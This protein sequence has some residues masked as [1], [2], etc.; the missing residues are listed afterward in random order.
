M[1][2]T[3]GDVEAVVDLTG[4]MLTRLVNEG[5]SLEGLF[6]IVAN[7]LIGRTQP[8]D[9]GRA[10]E[11]TKNKILLTGFSKSLPDKIGSI[12]FNQEPFGLTPTREGSDF[13]QEGQ[14]RY[15]ARITVSAREERSAGEEAKRSLERLLDALR[16]ELIHDPISVHDEFI[17]IPSNQRPAMFRFP[18]TVPNPK[19]NIYQAEFAE[20]LSLLVGLYTSERFSSE[21]KSKLASALRCYRMSLDTSQFQNRLVNSWTALE[22]LA[23][24]RTQK[25]IIDGVRG[26]VV[27]LLVI[28]YLRT[29]L[30]DFRETLAF[31]KARLPIA[32]ATAYGVSFYREL[33]LEQFL[34]AIRGP[35]FLQ[36]QA[37]CSAYPALQFALSH[38]QHEAVRCPERYRA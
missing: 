38:F 22:Y 21:T 17:C 31:I 24:D 32:I 2:L 10:F 28:P 35:H 4:R 18:S 37:S 16:F 27:P 1:A 19:K 20:F 5:Y 23:R 29:L 11:A 34:E 3:D 14:R 8:V 6:G 7:V 9:F 12:E 30:A 36:L 26:N 15:F 13:Y 25:Y 33:T